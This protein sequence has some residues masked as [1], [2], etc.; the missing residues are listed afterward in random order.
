MNSHLED[1][2]IGN[3]PVAV[4]VLSPRFVLERSPRWVRA[5]FDG[6][7]IAD[8]K[9][10]LLLRAVGRL[11]VYYFPLADVRAEMLERTSHTTPSEY[12]GD[13]SLWNVR[14]AHRVAED[15]AWSYDTLVEGTPDVRDHIAFYWDQMDAWYEEDERAYAHA[16]DPYTM[17]VDARH[18]TRHVRVELAG[19]TLAETRRPVLLFER[20]LPV[21]YYIP[22]EDVRMD[23]LM[24]SPTDTACAYK[25]RASHWNARIN[26]RDYADVA[27]TYREPLM[28]A[29]P[30]AGAVAF[31]QERVDAIVVDGEQVERPE[32]P[33]SRR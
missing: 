2:R 28:V 31:Y 25:G 14:G 7:T 29:T 15:A 19:V 18:S 23:L 27:W 9:A 32:T 13:A 5:E 10:V 20:G 21:R 17:G 26:V 8:S 24:P 30:V 6:V 16:R 1:R 22:S 4:A 11:P 33:W 3:L 12:K